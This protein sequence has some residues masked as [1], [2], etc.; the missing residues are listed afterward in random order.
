MELLEEI[1]IDKTSLLSFK[2]IAELW[3]FSWD[4]IKKHRLNELNRYWEHVTRM[5]QLEVIPEKVFMMEYLFSVYSAGFKASIVSLKFD[6]LSRAHGITNTD[7]DFV[8]ALFANLSWQAGYHQALAVIGNKMKAKA[9]QDTRGLIS[10]LGWELFH[11]TYLEGKDPEKIGKLPFMGPALRCHVARNLG[12][13]EVVKPDV[14]LNR[15]AKH[16]GF[17]SAHELCV[18]IYPTP[19]AFNDLVL[20]LTSADNRTR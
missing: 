17:E 7:G 10:G 11:K 13:M 20:W 16:Y 14:H 8:R 9:I 2:S 1:K 6:A 4:H 15:L 19:P 5:S 18:K 12:N 3:D